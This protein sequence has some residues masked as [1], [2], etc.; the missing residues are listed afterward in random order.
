MNAI[1][2]HINRLWN[3]RRGGDGNQTRQQQQERPYQKRDGHQQKERF[4]GLI[5]V[6]VVSIVVA[7]QADH[8]YSQCLK[9]EITH[10]SSTSAFSLGQRDLGLFATPYGGL[11]KFWWRQ[12]LT[13]GS[14]IFAR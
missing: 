7:D 4:W 2:T 3:D 1:P 11:C 9:K 5:N 14:K 8:D 10:Y 13:K 12:R 6:S